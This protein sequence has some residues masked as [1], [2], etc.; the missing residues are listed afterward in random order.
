[1]CGMMKHNFKITLVKLRHISKIEF[2]EYFMNSFL[3]YGSSFSQGHNVL[4]VFERYRL[5]L[6]LGIE[7]EEKDNQLMCVH[8]KEIQKTKTKLAKI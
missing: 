4:Q 5:S 1:M 3:C 2:N 6:I 8:R 7:P